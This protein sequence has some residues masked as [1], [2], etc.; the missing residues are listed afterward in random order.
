M[1][2]EEKTQD[3]DLEPVVYC[4]KCYS[5]KIKHDDVFDEDYCTDCGCTDISES[6]IEEWEE[7]Y[8]KRYGNKYTQKS[9]NVKESPYYKMTIQ[10]LKT[11]VF[12]HPNWKHIIRSI[13][14]G[15]PGGLTKVESVILLFN[16]LVDDNRMNELRIILVNESKKK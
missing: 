16:N 9:N 3:Y 5:L 1:S 2:D 11:V 13:Y 8:E 6:S 14:P 12:E 10:E 7:L 4:S 15:F